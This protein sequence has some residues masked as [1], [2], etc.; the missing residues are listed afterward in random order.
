[1]SHPA[2]TSLD[3]RA[4]RALRAT[5]LAAASMVGLVV[6]H[7]LDYT[8]IFR[9]PGARSAVLLNTGHSYF[10]RAIE[11]A[12][13]SGLL[14]IVGSVAV[15]ALDGHTSERWSRARVA[16]VLALIQSGGFVAL[17][18]GERVAAHAMAQRFV[19]V[20]LLGI[21][22]QVAVAI[23]TTFILGLFERAGQV[24]SR[25]P[26]VP[27]QAPAARPVPC[28]HDVAHPTS[29]HLRRAAPR[30]PPFAFSS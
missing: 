11:F 1:M 23:V 27:P 28:L 17:E 18:A 15:G 7:V 5:V 4:M 21:A 3:S 6:A 13:V 25:A 14:A 8:V 9:N 2:T 26:S 16:C 30:A 19:T 29:F 22:L 20:T 12:I 24:L 10:G